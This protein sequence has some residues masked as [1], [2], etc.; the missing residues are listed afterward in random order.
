L[1]G[2]I[3]RCLVWIKK[4]D[5][6]EGERKWGGVGN[7]IG[8]RTG[9]LWMGREHIWIQRIKKA[10]LPKGNRMRGREGK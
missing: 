9:L 1:D 7:R 10:D 4:A 5:L 6:P 3:Y 8:V 2:D